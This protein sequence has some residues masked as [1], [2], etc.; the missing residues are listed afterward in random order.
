MDK[1]KLTLVIL[2]ILVIGALSWVLYSAFDGAA[3]KKAI[4]AEN[5]NDICKAPEG[6]TQEEWE[7]HMSHHPDRYKECLS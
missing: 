1:E 3:Y 5:K 2:V 6:Y 4:N 7:E